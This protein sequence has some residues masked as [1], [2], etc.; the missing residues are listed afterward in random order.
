[1]IMIIREFIFPHFVI[2]TISVMCSAYA[3]LHRGLGERAKH[4][5][6]FKTIM[7]SLVLFDDLTQHL[8]FLHVCP[9]I[10]LDTNQF[11]IKTQ[12]DGISWIRISS[13]FSPIRF[14]VSFFGV[15]R[16]RGFASKI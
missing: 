1:M 6:N 8:S 15:R 7:L 3:L 16:L 5:R 13:L 9:S 14:L 2:L 12:V 11:N 4:D 10:T